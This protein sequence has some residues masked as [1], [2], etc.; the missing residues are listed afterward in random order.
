MISFPAQSRIYSTVCAEE[1]LLLY[2]ADADEILV[3]DSPRKGRS[4]EWN[5]KQT[6]G[7]RKEGRRALQLCPTSTL[8]QF[9]GVRNNFHLN[10]NCRWLCVL[11]AEKITQGYC[12]HY[13]CNWSCKESAWRMP[14]YGAK[15]NFVLTVP[16]GSAPKKR[17]SVQTR[18]FSPPP[19]Q[20]EREERER[21]DCAV[22]PLKSAGLP[23][24]GCAGTV[25]VLSPVEGENFIL[26]CKMRRGRALNK[27]YP[28]GWRERFS[29]GHLTYL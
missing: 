27:G 9:T 7:G 4:S 8:G 29:S 16:S 21:T 28:F 14:L 19:M 25:K 3:A 15:Y 11:T 6:A 24:I 12:F 22:C 18:H 13:K 10:F 17:P 5:R 20:T 26:R 2:S 23:E 1:L